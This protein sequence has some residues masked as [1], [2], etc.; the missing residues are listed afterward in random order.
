MVSST[1]LIDLQY[2]PPIAYF[3]LLQQYDKVIFEQFEHFQKA[4]YRNRSI[5]TGPNGPLRLSIPLQKGKNQHTLMKDVQICYTDHWQK[6]HWNSFASCY[7]RSPYFEYYEDEFEAVFRQETPSLM[8]FNL[9]LLQWVLDALGMEVSWALS[10]AFQ[11]NPENITDAR[12][13]IH[14]KSPLPGF[15]EF[16]P[17]VYHQVFEDRTGFQPNMSIVDLLFN[18][19]PKAILSL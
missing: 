6:D 12:S 2:L 14:P 8:Q 16:N 9:Q 10:T 4:S 3:K 15:F 11:K 1:L 17:P 7:R 5:I 18:E 13:A 19:G